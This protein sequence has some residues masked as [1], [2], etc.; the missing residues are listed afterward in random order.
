[1]NQ[2]SDQNFQADFAFMKTT[3]LETV[4]KRPTWKN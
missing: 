4:K 1:M 3:Y 2:E